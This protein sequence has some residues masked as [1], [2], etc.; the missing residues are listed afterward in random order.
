MESGETLDEHSQGHY[1]E[2]VAIQIQ[3]LN[4][5]FVV[6]SGTDHSLLKSTDKSARQSL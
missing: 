4:V 5:Y 1:W 6:Q 2:Y 3:P